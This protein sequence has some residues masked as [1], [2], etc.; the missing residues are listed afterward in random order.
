MS[1]QSSLACHTSVYNGHLRGP[2][3]LTAIAERLAVELS[4]PVLTTWV[5]RSW[6]S[7]T[8]HSACFYD[9]KCHIKLFRLQNL[10][11]KD[12]KNKTRHKTPPKN[13]TKR[14]IN[15]PMTYSLF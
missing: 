5:C 15:E 12:L 9:I 14:V 4:L 10:Y 13:K 8:Q 2:V 7:N 3:T 1:S 11:A 6:A